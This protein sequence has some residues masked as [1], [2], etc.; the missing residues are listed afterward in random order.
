MLPLLRALLGSTLR[1]RLREVK[2]LGQGHT[3]TKG[4]NSGLFA[5]AFWAF[6]TKA[7]LPLSPPPPLF[8]GSVSAAELSGLLRAAWT[9]TTS[10]PGPARHP[11]RAASTALVP[12]TSGMS[13]GECDQAQLTR[14]RADVGPPPTAPRG[15]AKT[16]PRIHPQGR[17]LGLGGGKGR[18]DQRSWSVHVR[19]RLRG[20]GLEPG[21]RPRW[22]WREKRQF[23]RAENPVGF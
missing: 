22:L 21:P 19:Q 12:H 11:S 9:H 17:V 18:E 8:S 3:A 20:S 23:F 4:V 6:S 14:L 10:R 2:Q 13:C 7:A 5:S 15:P 1:W 16:Q